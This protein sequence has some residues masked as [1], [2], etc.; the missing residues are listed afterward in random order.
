MGYRD[1]Y[2]FPAD[3]MLGMHDEMS[4]LPGLVVHEEIVDMADIASGGL[5]MVGPDLPATPEMRVSGRFFCRLL[6]DDRV[7]NKHGGGWDDT[8]GFAGKKSG[9]PIGFP[10]VVGS[11]FLFLLA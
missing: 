3:R 11:Q 1:E 2:F 5:D 6:V 8:H 4:D 10:G 9:S 7:G